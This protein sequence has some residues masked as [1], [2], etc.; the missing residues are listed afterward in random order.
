MSHPDVVIVGIMGWRNFN[1]SSSESHINDDIIGHNWDT[2]VDEGMQG[3]LP[4]KMLFGGDQV[5]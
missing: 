2:S 1:S 5:K 4:V 3:I